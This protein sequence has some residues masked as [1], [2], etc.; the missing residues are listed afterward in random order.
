MKN[1]VWF[2]THPIYATCWLLTGRTL[3]ECRERWS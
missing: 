3:S 1:L 2:V